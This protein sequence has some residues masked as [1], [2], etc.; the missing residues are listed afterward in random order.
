MFQKLQ[1][2]LLFVVFVIF[3]FFVVSTLTFTG[4]LAEGSPRRSD[5]LSRTQL[6]PY[7]L[8]QIMLQKAGG[9]VGGSSTVGSPCSTS[10]PSRASP[11]C[12]GHR[13]TTA[14]KSPLFSLTQ[15]SPILIILC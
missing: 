3:I 7:S 10:S 14:D 8:T 6:T 12:G 9:S 4:R 1:Y 5:L 13:P 11:T 15:F 2:I